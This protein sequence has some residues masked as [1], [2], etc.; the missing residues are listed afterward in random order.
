MQQSA[1]SSGG[2]VFI[3]YGWHDG[4]KLASRLAKDLERHEYGVFFDREDIG[5]GALFEVRIEEGINA[6]S[7]V[8]A[9]M[10]PYS[11]REESICRDEVVYALQKQKPVLPLKAD[12]QVKP[13]LLLARRNWIDFTGNYDEA[14]QALLCYLAGDDSRLNQPA[15]PTVTG[16]EPFDFGPELA[17]HLAH[18]AGRKWLLDEVDRWLTQDNRR[19]MVIVGDPGIG[20]SA[21]AAWLATQR[22][23]TVVGIH[24]C[25]DRNERTRV[26]YEFA[27]ALV[28]QLHATLPGFAEQLE[29][30]HPDVRRGTAAD[31]FRELIVEPLRH[32]TPTRPLV[33]IVDSLDEAMMQEGETILDV[34][35]LQARDLPIWFRIV[36]T[37][38]P[39]S[40]ILERMGDSYVYLL[41]PDASENTEDL[42]SYIKDRLATQSLAQRVGT[43]MAGTQQKVEELSEGNFLYASL[44]LDALENGSLAL[45]DL[46][47]LES[48]LSSY[49]SAIFVRLFRDTELYADE[50]APILRV[51][52]ASCAPL[53]FEAI[54]HSVGQDEEVIHRRLLKL[55]AFVRSTETRATTVYELFHKSLK[56]WLTDRNQKNSYYIS[57]K[58]GQERLAE[59]GWQEFRTNPTAMSEYFRR[60]LPVHLLE[61][62]RW[63]ELLILVLS[64][65]PGL[66][67][68]WV[69][70]GDPLGVKCCA[71][72]LEKASM[73]T[74]SQAML[75]TEL[76]RMHNYRGEYADAERRLEDAL[77][78]TSWRHG[79]RV[80]AIAIHELGSLYLFRGDVAS[81]TKE[82]RRALRICQLGMPIYRDEVAAN[83]TALATIAFREYRWQDCLQLANRA[84]RAANASG[85]HRHAI[86]AQR[87][88]GIALE[89]LERYDEAQDVLEKALEASRQL[90]AGVEITRILASLG[91]FAFGQA[92]LRGQQPGEAGI[93][94]TQAIEAGRLVHNLYCINDATLRLG[95]TLLCCGETAPA[96]RC[97]EQVLS[98]VP[99][100]AHAEMRVGAQIGLT[101][102]EHQQGHLPDTMTR[103][104][105]GR[106][107][108]EQANCRGWA[109]T[110]LI[111]EGAI[112]WHTGNQ[113]AAQTC[114][115]NA[116]HHAQRN[117][118]R[119]MHLVDASIALCQKSITI[120][121]R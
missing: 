47:R 18:F 33:M 107:L 65:F 70:C 101:A 26:P 103:Y 38:R 25:T 73:D 4:L 28:S 39:E 72:L 44:V 64:P 34:L 45:A 109:A 108:A 61:L 90:G 67:E 79:R 1:A 16:R 53:P 35:S 86:A 31:A 94:F 41:E 52:S 59:L 14:L 21:F 51:L 12:K 40:P 74:V 102:A 113:Q 20:K 2:S 68:Q 36:A 116:R 66:L 77:S 24:F 5:K 6:S 105:H 112:L 71:K 104:R 111:G 19:M 7:V 46:G 17:K 119:A 62:E 95:W 117:S 78:L 57:E 99:Q 10:T 75:A 48:G 97:F 56:D 27:A 110:A 30:H 22:T 8:A 121:P 114:W 106:K 11:V 63:T 96:V 54:Q 118:P 49:Y 83:L 80:H 58:E 55:S 15:L 13:T 115:D 9:V 82:Y 42:G 43:C 89:D 100:N 32:L 37:T 120:V 29:Q 88:I 50:Y 85:D 91:S 76:A 98:A 92:T 69:D 93:C 3:S 81:A 84:L 60:Y 87:L 23:D